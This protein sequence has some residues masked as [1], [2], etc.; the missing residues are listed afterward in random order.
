LN[1]IFLALIITIIILVAGLSTCINI[2]ITSTKPPIANASADVTFGQAP[3]NISFNASGFDPDNGEIKFYHW[4]FGD[5]NTSNKKNPIHTYQWI[6]KF[7]A[8]LTVTDDEGEKGTDTLEINIINYQSPVAIA[9]A[10]ITCGKAPLKIRFM[11]S[12]FDVDG[13][14][15]EYEWDFGD[16]S[17]DNNQN[18][19]HTY[20]SPGRYFVILKVIDNDRIIGIDNIEINALENYK[21]TAIAWADVIDGKAPLTVNFR[22]SGEDIDG[23]ILSYHWLFEDAIIESNRESNNKNTAHT[24]WF[25]GT[26]LVKFTVFDDDGAND[27]VEIKIEVE[28]SIFSSFYMSLINF[29]LRR[30]KNE[31]IKVIINKV[32]DIIFRN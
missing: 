4:D 32:L 16:G 24:F 8:I 29:T 10:N 30:V 1:K 27:T 17:S 7:F 26:Y 11:G 28:E 6:G 25:P 15:M 13:I 3:L 31:C 23:T 2:I 22:G 20:E 12:G 18:V 21:P 9:S 5:G 14:I 19:I